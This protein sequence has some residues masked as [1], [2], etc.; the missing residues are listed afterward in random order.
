MKQIKKWCWV[1]TEVK[2]GWR[3]KLAYGSK[4]YYLS[5]L[6][7]NQKSLINITGKRGKIVFLHLK[8]TK[9]AVK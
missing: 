4:D 8:N 7:L 3:L 2:G 6:V 9:Y 1:A 5:G